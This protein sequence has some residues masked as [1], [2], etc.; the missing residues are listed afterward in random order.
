M[1]LCE[2]KILL[3]VEISHSTELIQ[4]RNMTGNTIMRLKCYKRLD[5]HNG[6]DRNGDDYSSAKLTME[7]CSYLGFIRGATLIFDFSDSVTGMLGVNGTR[8]INKQSILLS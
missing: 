4:F 8:Q 1:K 6:T 3:V 7:E 2:I 5:Y